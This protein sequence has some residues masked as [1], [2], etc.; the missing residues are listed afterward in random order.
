MQPSFI[1]KAASN[2]GAA[3]E[4]CKDLVMLI[5]VQHVQLVVSSIHL[6]WK[7]WVSRHHSLKILRSRASKISASHMTITNCLNN[8]LQQ[9]SVKLWSYNARLVYNL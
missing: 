3:A 9:L 7:L 5:E 2:A 1:T 4:A 6:L 8:L